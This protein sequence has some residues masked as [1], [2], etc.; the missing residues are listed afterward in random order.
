MAKTRFC[1]A[2]SKTK[3]NQYDERCSHQYFKHRA[4]HTTL[5]AGVV[6]RGP[7]S[8]TAFGKESML[9]ES[10]LQGQLLT[11]SAPQAGHMELAS[12]MERMDETQ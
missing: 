10:L 9:Q 3:T 6:G 8:M 4:A 5:R 1:K 7:C 2:F 11:K 12:T